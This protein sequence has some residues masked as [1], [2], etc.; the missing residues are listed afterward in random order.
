MTGWLPLASHSV[1]SIPLSHTCCGELDSS[2]KPPPHHRSEN[3]GE[4]VALWLQPGKGVSGVCCFCCP[5]ASTRV[6]QAWVF[7]VLLPRQAVRSRV[8]EGQACCLSSVTME[9]WRR[10]HQSPI[11]QEVS[12][13]V[14]PTVPWGLLR[15]S[16]TN[17]NFILH[18]LLISSVNTNYCSDLIPHPV[19]LNVITPAAEQ[20]S[21]TCL[22]HAISISY[23]LSPVSGRAPESKALGL[24]KLGV[25]LDEATQKIVVGADESTSVPNIFAF[26]DI[27]EVGTLRRYLLTAGTL[28]L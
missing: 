24:N 1:H 18:K 5:I 21:N 6:P 26:G 23:L 27:S 28:T 25:Q 16:W 9:T 17:N 10:Q 4:G 19:V 13:Y 14:P 11:S 8:E 12:G 3:K 22:S 2:L 7:I 15:L 20:A